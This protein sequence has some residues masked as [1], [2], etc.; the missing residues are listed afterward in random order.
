MTVLSTA[1][2]IVRGIGLPVPSTLVANTNQDARRLLQCI[3]DAGRFLSR[4]EWNAQ[5]VEATISCT[6]SSEYP[7]PSG[8]RS[9]VPM[10]IWKVGQSEPTRGPIRH[11]EWQSIKYGTSASGIYDKFHIRYNGTSQKFFIT[12]VPATADAFTYLYRREG[13]VISSGSVI[14]SCSADTDTFLLDDY[15]IELEAKWRFLKAIGQS[16]GEE[17]DEALRIRQIALAED[18]GMEPIG[19]GRAADDPVAWSYPE[20]NYG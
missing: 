4:F 19:A 8:F 17:K 14:A 7:I 11:V 1:Q 12:P 5:V 2:N 16:Y 9:I 15:L 3:N 13:W 20:R 6:G 18:G 10:T